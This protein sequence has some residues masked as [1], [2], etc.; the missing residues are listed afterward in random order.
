MS[1]PNELL[2]EGAKTGNIELVRLA[3][4]EGACDLNEAMVDT[5]KYGHT[6][7]VKLLLEAGGNNYDFAM[8]RAAYGGCLDIVELCWKGEQQTIVTRWQERPWEVI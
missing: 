8:A 1:L 7:I 6:D 5:A 2:K 3:L 4:K